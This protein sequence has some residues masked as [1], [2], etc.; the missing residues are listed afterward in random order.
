MV[1]EVINNSS[2]IYN[3]FTFT[4]ENN[5]IKV[6]DL[7]PGVSYYVNASIIG[8]LPPL[9]YI[10]ALAKGTI[11]YCFQSCCNDDSFYF[12]GT[13]NSVF[14]NYLNGE[15][16]YFNEALLSSNPNNYKSGCYELVGRGLSATYDCNI[17]GSESVT[18]VQFNVNQ[19]NNCDTC[20][21]DNS[22]CN[23]YYVT[24]QSSQ[25]VKTRIEFTPCCDEEKKSPYDLVPQTSVSICS[26][27]GVKVLS[28]EI[29]IINNGKCTPCTITTTTNSIVTTTTTFAPPNPPIE[30]KNEC[31][32]ITI[33]PLGV[34]CFIVDPSTPNSF[35][36]LI[37]L[38]ITGGT[39]PYEVI[40]ENGSLS[41]SLSNLGVGNYDSIVT[42]YYGDFTA[43][44]TCVLGVEIPITT[45]TTTFNPLPTYEDICLTIIRRKL[46]QSFAEYYEFQYN[47]YIGDYPTWED[48]TNSLDIVWNLNGNQWQVSGWTAGQIINLNI[49]SPPLSGWNSVGSSLPNQILSITANLG[50]CNELSTPNLTI[51]TNR[52]ECGC[53]GSIILTP[54]GGTPPYVYSINGGTTYQPTTIYNN[55]CEG[56]YI[57]YVRDSSGFTSTQTVVLPPPTS[58]IN[59]I[60][61]MSYASTT[62]GTNVFN[63]NVSPSLPIGTTI[64]FDVIH[65]NTFNVGPSA[66]A[67]TYNNIVTLNVNGL[68]VSNTNQTITPFSPIPQP[69]PCKDFF[70]YTTTRQYNWIN[71]SMT[72]GTI[73]NGSYTDTISPILP[74]P[75]CFIA[76]RYYHIYLNNIKINNNCDTVRVVNPLGVGIKK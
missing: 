31:D 24:N 49:G 14:A 4:D 36:G 26:S 69:D 30:P 64:T 29:Q 41:Q 74:T 54:F 39:P 16:I 33:F 66:A 15:I 60:V 37:T 75:H 53:D 20:V 63:I 68:P 55:L 62:S 27:T 48:T 8:T 1:F 56:S 9:L 59:Y 76:Y 17:V 73:I 3:N 52:P 23:N 51:N 28:G 57:V 46:T 32:V 47:G 12:D 70:K 11:R 61:T 40:W 72:S 21:I 44:T 5:V 13:V 2:V 42:D 25:N 67:A 71:L 65:T 10:N 34:E 18:L 6:V 58:S 19:Y 45:S 50:P 7:L 38:G 43:Y 35:D 22:C